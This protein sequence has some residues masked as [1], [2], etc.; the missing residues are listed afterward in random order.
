MRQPRATVKSQRQRKTGGAQR[1]R[2]Q[3]D[4]KNKNEIPTGTSDKIY[5]KHNWKHESHTEYK[6]RF[7]AHRFFIEDTSKIISIYGGHGPPFFILL[8]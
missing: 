3:G 5:Y 8:L 7:L 4:G 1:T 2:K 6:N